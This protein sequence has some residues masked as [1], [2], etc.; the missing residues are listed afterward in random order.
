[1]RLT[2]FSGY[3]ILQ[4]EAPKTTVDKNNDGTL[5]Y[6]ATE[7]FKMVEKKVLD[8]NDDELSYDMLYAYKQADLDAHQ[9][10]ILGQEK[11]N[12]DIC[13][14]L[15]KNIPNVDYKAIKDTILNNSPSTEQIT[16]INNIVNNID[17]IKMLQQLK[18]HY[19][20]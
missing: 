8:R 6:T 4:R 1:M 2:N 20:R 17:K 12:I 3:D 7:M 11:V 5:K 13:L 14:K 10:V 18:D 9:K 16:E 19:D 15:A